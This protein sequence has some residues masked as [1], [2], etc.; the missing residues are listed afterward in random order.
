MG[1]IFIYFPTSWVATIETT[2]ANLRKEVWF[3]YCIISS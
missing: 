2:Q 3:I 1:F